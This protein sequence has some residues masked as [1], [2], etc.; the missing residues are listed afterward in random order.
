MERPVSRPRDQGFEDYVRAKRASLLRFAMV[1]T[2]GDH[3]VAEDLV[4]TALTRLYVAWPRAR[5]FSTDA[6]ARRIVVNALIDEK[7]R[8]AAR[9]ETITA[10]PPERASLDG[11]SGITADPDLLQALAALPAGMRAAVVCR[12]VEGLS[13]EETASVLRCTPGN[14]KSQTARGLARLRELLAEQSSVSVITESPQER[15]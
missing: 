11:D 6:Y 3:Y 13:V 5:S 2:A 12:H 14:V 10:Q 9:R 4:Q 1:L 15:P 8:H 7:R